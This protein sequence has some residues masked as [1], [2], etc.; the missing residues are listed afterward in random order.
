MIR[1]WISALQLTELFVSSIV[2]LLYGFYIFSSAVA[3]D[4]SQVLNE[5]FFKPNVNV[6]EVKQEPPYVPTAKPTIDPNTLPPIVL[7]HGIFGFGKGVCHLEF[8]FF[9]VKMNAFFFF[10]FSCIVSIL[11]LDFLLLET[12]RFIVFCGGREER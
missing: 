4:L 8:S 3:G 2:H 5:Y 9:V 10:S 1:W 7:V 6:I 11:K 12:G